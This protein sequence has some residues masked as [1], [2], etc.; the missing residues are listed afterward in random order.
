MRIDDIKRFI[1]PLARR[2]DNMVA[3]AVVRVMSDETKLQ[4]MQAEILKG[5]V[6]DNIERFQEYGFTSVPQ[7]GAEAV[8]VFAGGDR[9]HGL[10]IAVDDRRYRMKKMAKGEVAIYTDEGDHIHFK[11]DRKIKVLA[12]ARI[13]AE[14]PII[15]AVAA[16]SA[17][18]TS[19]IIEAIAET[20]ATLTSPS[21]TINAETEVLFNTPKATF[22]GEV[23]VT[24]K[25]TSKNGIENSNGITDNDI[26]VG[27]DHEHYKGT[28][29]HT[30]NTGAPKS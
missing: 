19:P 11:R 6:R 4:S 26:N 12:G 5:E 10:I 21:V 17:K 30:G 29:P 3:R 13:D 22:S 28:D 24:D 27:Y 16:T 1:A 7:D 18:I 2:V 9:S 25:L 15:E 20:S 8:V 14:A 23:E